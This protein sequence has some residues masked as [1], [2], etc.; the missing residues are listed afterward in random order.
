MNAA[1]ENAAQKLGIGVFELF[2]R[3]RAGYGTAKDSARTAYNRYNLVG[4]VPDFVEKFLYSH[5]GG[6]N[7]HEHSVIPVRYGSHAHHGIVGGK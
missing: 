4:E 2:S 5:Q 1:V 6:H 7:G 3:A